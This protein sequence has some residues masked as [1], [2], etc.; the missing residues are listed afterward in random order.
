[1][2][3]TCVCVFVCVWVP[4]EVA[5]DTLC[6]R[7]SYWN[8]GNCS[9]SNHIVGMVWVGSLSEITCE[10]DPRLPLFDHCR[11]IKGL[12]LMRMVPLRRVDFLRQYFIFQFVPKCLGWSRFNYWGFRA[13]LMVLMVWARFFKPEWYR[14]HPK[15]WSGDWFVNILG[16]DILR[17][18]LLA[19]KLFCYNELFK[20]AP[21][22]LI[23]SGA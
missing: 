21:T 20:T 15:I 19:S 10:R 4:C 14:N 1:M 13:I 6:R 5:F 8:T 17:D 18:N 22:P 7:G 2:F 11:V 9:K 16:C 3:A 12:L 23:R